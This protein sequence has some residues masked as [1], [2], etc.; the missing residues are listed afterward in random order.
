MYYL[1]Y[2][3]LYLVS[4]LP[5]FIL[6]RISDFAYFII[7]R[8]VGYRKEVVMN[9]LDIAFPEK[10]KEE[11]KQ[12][13]KRFYRNLTDTFIET[14]KLL[15]ISPK[16]F[17]KRATVDMKAC[18]ALAASGKN[19]QCHTGH[20]MNWEYIHLA[21]SKHI[22]IPWVGVY[23]PISNK[24]MDR[25]FLKIRK[26][27]NAVML[28]TVDFKKDIR[29][30]YNGRYAI[31]LIADQNPPLPNNAYWLYFFTK[32]AP[33]IPGPEKSAVRN[34]TAV[35]FVNFVKVKRGY[36]RAEPK[37]IAEQ[38]NDFKDGELTLLYRD[39]LEEAIR[40]QPETYLW[41]HRRWRWDYKPEEHKRRWIDKAV[42]RVNSE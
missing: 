16:S 12:I 32:A 10:T 38:A 14:I 18:N 31:G 24:Q 26:R 25:L 6:Y 36:Y 23:M 2:G 42:P 1:L 37:I 9:N 5:F 11:K 21:F 39:F 28:S 34:N 22:D 4:L 15:S 7:Y 41:S 30:I 33:F 27:F 17:D 13:A 8:I 35:V 29:A 19:I 20:Q 3:F 40:Q